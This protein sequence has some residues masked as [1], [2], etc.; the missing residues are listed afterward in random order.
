MSSSW[1]TRQTLKLVETE[2]VSFHHISTGLLSSK[3]KLNQ[4]KP[5]EQILT[6]LFALTITTIIIT[7]IK[8]YII[9]PS[10]IPLCLG[11]MESQSL[12]QMDPEYGRCTTLHIAFHCIVSYCFYLHCI[13]LCPEY[14]DIALL[15]FE[16]QLEH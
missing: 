9:I 10:S 2:L 15:Y 6:L 4:A 11:V 14:L 12:H 13:A 7:I 16:F 3:L 1:K 5:S 8:I